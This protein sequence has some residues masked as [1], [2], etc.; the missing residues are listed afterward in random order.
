MK[1]AKRAPGCKHNTHSD[2]SFAKANTIAEDMR[3]VLICAVLLAGAAWPANV[4]SPFTA[5]KRVSTTPILSPEGG[6][7][8]AA[9][10]FN[11]AVIEHGGQ[12]VMIYRAQDKKGISRLGYATSSDGIH[13][14]RD[15]GPVLSPEAPYEKNGGLEDP[16]LVKI[17]GTYYL[18]Y[19]GYN[20]VDA[21]LCLA[22]STDLKHWERMGVIL[23]ANRGRWN[24]HWTKSGAILSEKINGHYWMYFMA[25]AAGEGA[26]QMGVAYSDDL[27]HWTE[28]L[29][30]PILGHRQGQFDAKVVEPGPPP[31][32]TEKGILLIYNGADNKLA[33]R[34]GWALFDR[35]DPSRV[36]ARAE[37]PI[38]G[39]QELWE[40][41]GQVPNVV[42]V[43]GLLRR[44]DRWIFYYG[45]ADKYIGAAS[46]ALA[47]R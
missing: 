5:W 27:V 26:N 1:I 24:V 19:T 9:G 17:G 44:P 33:Y 46:A 12:I 36:I 22:K 32:L 16:R 43:E 8:E 4:A 47:W 11:P 28:S 41:T 3:I 29:D 14:R 42:F 40:T 35:T 38:F 18:T 7:F 30:H 21:Q 31:V 10:V 45:G 13:F 25:D 6:G 37:N 15:A 2:F 34:T 23:P 39:P 20:G